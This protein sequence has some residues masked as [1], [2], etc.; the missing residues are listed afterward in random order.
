MLT[1]SPQVFRRPSRAFL[2]LLGALLYA[3][4][5]LVFFEATGRMDMAPALYAVLGFW[6]V[7]L[8]ALLFMD[9]PRAPF[10]AGSLTF[11]KCVWANAGVVISAL[12]VHQ[13][14]RLLFLVVPLL[15]IVH[16]ALRLSR[17]QVGYVT[18]FTWLAYLLAHPLLYADAG[19]FATSELTLTLGFSGMLVL[20]FLMAGEVTALR[21]AF[22][23]RNDR[24]N[25]ALR[26]LSDLAM[27]DDLTGLYNRRYI[28]EVLNR[29]KALGDRGH[30]GFTLCY[31]DLDHFKRINDRFGHQEGDRALQAFA[32]VAEQE[33]RSVD[34]VARFGGEEFLLVL[35]DADGAAAL[36]VAE[37]LAA[38]ARSLHVVDNRPDSRLTVS[39]GIAEFRSGESVESVIH[40]ADKA[41]YEAKSS[42]RDRIVQG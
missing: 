1:L 22:Q 38:R 39:I 36:R 27:R 5:C 29:Q 9:H 21:G 18:L 4:V 32:R 8:G 13:Q 33:V 24:L 7:G 23:R 25:A 41:L 11:A 40:R 28:M 31:C 35:V 37:R 15:G 34:F 17:Q 12:F 2:V 10:D 3:V 42:G 19:P 16:A 26:K 6:A 30:V 14:L 20:M